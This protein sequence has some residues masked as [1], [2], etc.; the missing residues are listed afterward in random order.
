MSN[1]FLIGFV[2]F[3]F[4]VGFC[5]YQYL[6]YNSKLNVMQQQ[7]ES[8]DKMKKETELVYSKLQQT[9]SE[10]EAKLL[11]EN[12]DLKDIIKQQ[13]EKVTTYANIVVE[14]KKIIFELQNGTII[15]TLGER[16]VKFQGY[17]KPYTVDG[18]V[19][20]NS[21]QWTLGIDRDSFSLEFIITQT[22]F[23]TI[24][25]LYV[26]IND[27]TLRIKNIKFVVVPEHKAW[28]QN[29]K[30][31]A[32]ALYSK[33]HGPGIISGLG[34]GKYNAGILLHEQ[35]IGGFLIREF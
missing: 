12:K 35:S 34:F 8:S 33:A 11:I 10:K 15:D 14:Q 13:K 2:I 21:G 27:S 28:Y 4:I 17:Q 23:G 30:F 1:R 22:K 16:L 3:L 31:L 29:F 18:S 19:H 32:G 20:C 6:H 9:S 25:K 24:K 26:S 7:I 5:W